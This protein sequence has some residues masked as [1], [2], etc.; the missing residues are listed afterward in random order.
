MNFSGY[1]IKV[2]QHQVYGRTLDFVPKFITF[3]KRQYPG[4]NV[5]DWIGPRTPEPNPIAYPVTVSGG[6]PNQAEQ[7]KKKLNIQLQLH[8]YLTRLIEHV[9]D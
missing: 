6:D 2:F 1:T 3:I 8:L 7:I 9:I 5:C 4:A